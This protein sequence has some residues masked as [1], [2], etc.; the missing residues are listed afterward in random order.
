MRAIIADNQWVYFD[1]ITTDEEDVLWREF[2]V[3]EPNVYIDPNQMGQWDGVYRKYNRAKKRIARPLLS[4]LLEICDKHKLVLNVV[5]KREPWA[6]KPM[7]PGDITPD[8]LPGI[9][10]DPHQV[11]ATKRAC[12]LECGIVDVPTGGGK[13]E[14]I[15]CIAKAISCP[16]V[17]I[18]DQTIVISQLKQRLELRD[19][20]EEV[21][22]FYAGRRP[23]DELVVVGSIQSL[24]PP[25][26][27]PDVPKRKPKETDAAFAKRLEKWDTQ[28]KAFNT[29]RKNA[30]FLQQYVKRAEM[31]M[32]DECVDAKAYINTPSGM[33]TAATL[34]DEYQKSNCLPTVSVAGLSYD[35][36]GVSEKYESPINVETVRGRS[37]QVSANHPFAVF[38]DGLRQDIQAKNL[39]PNDLLLVNDSY[40]HQNVDWDSPTAVLWRLIGLFIGD[41][42][43]LNNKQVKFGVRKDKSDWRRAIRQYHALFAGKYSAIDNTR[44][45]LV[46][47]VKSEYFCEK[48]KEL[49]F[50]P[51]RKMGSIHPQ[52]S[53]PNDIATIACLR[54]LFD[55]DGSHHAGHANFD[56]SDQYLASFVQIALSSLGIKSS[57]YIGN[58]RF[59]EKHAIGWRVSVTS[60]DY[61]RFLE[62]IGFGFKRKSRRI[63]YRPKSEGARYIDPEPYLRR[64]SEIIPWKNV[65]DICGC[66]RSKLHDRT[67][68]SL[69]ELITWQRHILA[70][71]EDVVENYLEAKRLYG[72]SDKKIAMGCGMSTTTSWGHRRDGDDSLWLA[73]VEKI[74]NSLGHPLVDLELIGYAVE[75]VRQCNILE[76]PI[77][78]IDLTVDSVASFEANGLL[79]HNCD[80]ASSQQYKNLFRHQFRG[81]RRY[82]F[83]GTPMDAE[84]PV[85]AMVMQEHLGSPFIKVGRRYLER[86]GRIITCEYHMLSFGIDGDIKEA[87]AYDIAYDSVIVKNNE[88]HKL[89]TSICTKFKGDSTLILVDRM[90]LGE[91]LER[92]ITAAGLTTH[93]ICGKTVKRRRD[94]VLRAFERKEF[95]VLIG[96]KIINRGLDLSGGCDNLIIATGGKLESDFIQKVGRA[97]RHNTKGYS[98]VFD[99]Y[100]RC[101]R[102]LYHHSQARLRT[103]VNAG[104]RT[105]V[106]FPGGKID[107]AQFVQNRFRV[108]TNLRTKPDSRQ[109][110][111]F[112]TSGGD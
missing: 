1:H 66:S 9:T 64:W 2:S 60:D 58:N 22:M 36:V 84:K 3:S 33:K 52:F 98:R 7:D 46:I 28:L 68:V 35:V 87:S 51:G 91:N 69:S 5:D 67:K 43:F 109:R 72:I 48:L 103:M 42:H 30:K 20:A 18:A 49:D 56:S 92:A 12:K 62:T 65:V 82:G 94:E 15:C 108:T 17:I 73:H 53:L 99:F 10:L 55:A 75:P 25:T 112:S 8:F 80:K 40:C 44:G 21:G 86:I 27:P 88:F 77:R 106:Y 57:L 16:T 4:K 81:R 110:R 89:V 29:R 23:N 76:Q 32:V 105:T 11:E 85:A 93:F 37:L 50:K 90:E 61:C 97:L 6:Y 38:R 95:D 70:A 34:Y 19:V 59:N 14:I 102:Y 101:N 107:G 39:S 26:T 63:T 71:A 41:G 96:G 31:I 104:Y 74:R 78:L 13:G 79:V 54:G 47:R 45:D 83:S 111:L 100:F 24:S